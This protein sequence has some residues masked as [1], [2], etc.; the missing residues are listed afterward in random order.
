MMRLLEFPHSHYCEKARWALDYKG[1]PYT[2]EVIM[3]GF[4]VITLRKIA[5]DT[6][7]PVLID[8]QEV[9]QGSGEIISYLDS[10]YP[11]KRLTPLN[12]DHEKEC[13]EIENLV[14][15]DIGE[16][17]RQILYNYLLAYPDF[18]CYCF[19]HSM[20]AYKQMMFRALYPVLKRKIY[21]T[22]VISDQEVKI[23]RQK[24]DQTMDMLAKLLEGKKYL[25]G[26]QF[27]RADITV[28]SML[29]F[30]CFPQEHPFPWIKFPAVEAESFYQQYNQHPVS[31]WVIEL[32]SKHRNH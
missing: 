14:D 27:S 30:I 9:I 21:Q 12:K 25:V 11:E 4:H 7:V 1:V 26:D 16:T 15:K 13:I 5:K 8:E 20:P 10:K 18:I 28:A 2:A 24:F 6:S 3:P 22:Y 23:A 19:T 29:A 31:L 32:Y 17:I